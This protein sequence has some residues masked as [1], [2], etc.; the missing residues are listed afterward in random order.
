MPRVSCPRLSYEGA[1]L[2]ALAGACNVEPVAE[3]STGSAAMRAGAAVACLVRLVLALAV[4]PVLVSGC[5]L[6]G[7]SGPTSYVILEADTSALPAE[8]DVD[9][10]M[11][12]VEAIMKR[13]AEEF[14]G[15]V[16]QAQRQE[17]NRLALELSGMTAEEAR[18]NIGRTALL[19]FHEPE[20]DEE[21]NVVC[22]SD[23]GETV[24][25]PPDVVETG[26][27]RWPTNLTTTAE[28]PQWLCIPPG[29]TVPVGTVN[30]VP[31]TGIGSDGQE[32]ALTSRFLRGEQTE[33]IL[34]PAGRPFVQIKFSSEGGDLFEQITTRLLGLPVAIFLDEELI[35]APTVQG[36]LRYDAVIQGLEPDEADTL[37]RQL[38]AGALPV[39]VRVIAVGEGSPP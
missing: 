33:A 4:W 39:S 36:I 32:K 6:M 26:A 21:G 27:G 2:P 13:R 38:R 9:R 20:R 15:R 23:T 30:W 7:T 31:A 1:P 17:T 22:T 25:V 19:V 14:G 37:A 8:V 3:E 5:G 12:E 35:S 16:Q 28:D 11:E 29:A 24:T 10:A 34:H 18:E